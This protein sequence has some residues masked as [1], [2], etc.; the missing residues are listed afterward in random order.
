MLRQIVAVV[1]LIAVPVAASLAAEGDPCTFTTQSSDCEAGEFCEIPLGAC[2]AVVLGQCTA[3]PDECDDTDEPVCGCNLVTYGNRCLS[4]V[5]GAPL[6][7]EGECPERCGGIQGIGCTDPDQS[8]YANPPEVC[9]FDLSGICEDRPLT[10]PETCDPVCSCFGG[11][12]F[13][14]ECEA[15]KA[16]S[17]NWIPAD[18]D[19]QRIVKSV[20]FSSPTQISWSSVGGAL[21]YNLYRETTSDPRP[22]DV[23]ECLMPDLPTTSATLS[24]VPASGE[25]WLLQIGA[26]MADGEGPL[27]RGQDCSQ[28]APVTPCSESAIPD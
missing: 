11:Q 14:N 24:E 3:I 12:P 8:C 16:Y 1:A 22:H 7:R 19:Q 23:G 15:R 6:F 28:R 26:V 27:G 4:V 17:M 2:S 10:C 18:C 13:D 5:A 25:A 9:G 20:V 21:G